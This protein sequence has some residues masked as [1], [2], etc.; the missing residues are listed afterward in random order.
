MQP[1]NMRDVNP[2]LRLEN[3][4]GTLSLMRFSPATNFGTLAGLLLLHTD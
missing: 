1:L 3:N 4:G 2:V